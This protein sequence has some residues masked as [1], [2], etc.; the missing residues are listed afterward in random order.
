MK[1]LVSALTKRI[2]NMPIAVKV[3]LTYLP[4]ISVAFLLVMILISQNIFS[5]SAASNS[6][7]SVELVK[8][9][10]KLAHN[11]AVERGLTAGYLGS[12]GS[13]GLSSLIQQ[14]DQAN[15]AVVEFQSFLEKKQSDYGENIQRMIKNLNQSVSQVEAL[16]NKVDALNKNNQAFKN[17]SDINK[18]ALDIISTL[19]V[20]AKDPAVI[21]SINALID[22][23][24][25]KERAGQERGAVNGVFAKRQY[26][27]N[28]IADIQ[29]YISDQ[30]S[31]IE[32]VLRNLDEEQQLRFQAFQKTDSA[33]KVENFRRSLIQAVSENNEIDQNSQEWFTESTNRIKDIKTQTDILQAAVVDLAEQ[34]YFYSWLSLITLV[35][36]VALLSYFIIS[37]SKIVTSVLLSRV[38]LLT[39]LLSR[40]QSSMNFSDRIEQPFDKDTDEIGQ[41]CMAT[42]ALL[43]SISSAIDDVCITMEKIGKGEFSARLSLELHGDL[44][45]L[46]NGINVS[47]EKVDTTMT[48]LGDVMDALHSGDFS[49][50][51]SDAVEGEFKTRVDN[52]MIMTNKAFDEIGVVMNAV[53]RGDFSLR[54]EQACNGQLDILKN[55]VNASVDSIT[56]ALNEIKAVVLEQQ[57]GNFKVKIKGGYLGELLLVKNYINDSMQSI[58]LA[59]GEIGSVFSKLRGGDFSGYI[60]ADLKGQLANMKTDINS[61]MKDL[62]NTMTDISSIVES[63]K[64]GDLTARMEG[65]YSGTLKDIASAMNNGMNNLENTVSN[66]KRSSDH[67]TNTSKELLMAINDLSKRTE[68]QAA[69]L[70]EITSSIITISELTLVSESKVKN[71]TE[72]IAV[73]ASE[74]E[75]SLKTVNQTI[76]A[77]DSMRL[78][79]E[80]ITSITNMINEIAF[81]TNLL[82]LNAAVE[83]ARAGEHGRGF[84]VVAAEVR[85]LAQRSSQ[86]TRDIKL[87]IDKNLSLVNSCVELTHQ[88]S[89]NLHTISKRVLAT[90]EF[91]NLASKSSKEQ[92]TGIFGVKSAISDIDSMTQENAAMV[93][94]ATAATMSV[95]ELSMSVNKSLD[96]FTSSK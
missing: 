67:A 74:T 37:F 55:T 68:N 16:R 50:R 31:R 60:D 57:S 71:V 40:V 48:S 83:A 53:S 9:L 62:Q 35:F 23:L 25:L 10:D 38:S 44:D 19:A 32:R 66:I 87:L 43:A 91:T 65:S 45:R 85:N 96:F 92:A 17:Y 95:S 89:N 14:R 78:S 15:L 84:S 36:S 28:N 2:E 11:F 64:N 59:L 21:R 94:E 88:S 4:I 12:G 63:Q 30:N 80:E 13:Q 7:Q 49:A 93:E 22:G 52:A 73:V 61:S 6:L 39:G 8:R 76:K 70:E 86:A 58:D 5:I 79:S 75:Q 56:T 34:T 1:N 46:K 27:I 69:S 51:M 18:Q 54:V 29:L 81:Q 20:D 82:A 90:K 26:S 42:N 3:R 47:A 72:E 33:Q 24:W 77:M 41:A